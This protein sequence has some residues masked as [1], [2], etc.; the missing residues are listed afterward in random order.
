MERALFRKVA[1]GGKH[2]SA[3]GLREAQNDVEFPSG[4]GGNDA[5]ADPL[6][7]P[8]RSA[9]DSG[10]P[11]P[12]IPLRS[13]IR[14]GKRP[15]RGVALCSRSHGRMARVPGAMFPSPISFRASSA[16]LILRHRTCI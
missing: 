1:A 6:A 12:Q 11:T 13:A 5:L 3:D 7:D 9:G 10:D 4:Q 16:V 15:M 2:P 8:S 14:H